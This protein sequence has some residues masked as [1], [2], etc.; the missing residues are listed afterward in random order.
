M[1]L[2]SSA[3]CGG[4]LGGGDVAAAHRLALGVL[5]GVHRGLERRAELRLGL[6][7]AEI[8][9]AG[10]PVGAEENVRG[11][12]VAMDVASG[13][14]VGEGGGELLEEEED[15]LPGGAPTELVDQGGDGAVL[16]VG[17]EEVVLGRVRAGAAQGEDVGMAKV[18]HETEL[19][20]VAVDLRLRKGGEEG[21]SVEGQGETKSGR[22][23]RRDASRRSGAAKRRRATTHLGREFGF[24]HSYGE[25]VESPEVHRARGTVVDATQLVRERRLGHRERHLARRAARTEASG[26][27]CG[28]HDSRADATARIKSPRRCSDVLSSPAGAARV[29]GWRS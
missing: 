15:S 18:E 4:A 20:V 13:V 6:G 7:E 27:L 5:L 8:G 9:E 3:R 21:G 23:A 28:R 16:L 14:D 22:G 19:D 1:S 26:R 10:D 2:K 24:L 25:V 12:D 29:C 17:K 11:F